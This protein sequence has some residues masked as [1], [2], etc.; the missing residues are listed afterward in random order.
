VAAGANHHLD[1][2]RL[3]AAQSVFE[4]AAMVVCQL[5]LPLPV[6]AHAVVLAQ[7]HAVPVLLNP[8]PALALPESLLRGLA[9]L[10][11]NEGE[12]ALLGGL[13]ISDVPSAQ[14]A[15]A[16]LRSAG[17]ACVIV[18]LGARG[19]VAASDMGGAAWPALPVAAID[20]TGA[21]DAFV[22]AFAVAQSRGQPLPES[23]AFAQRAAAWSVQRR[24]AQAA[25]PYADDLDRTDPQ[26]P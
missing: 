11:P 18:T 1:A 26:A 10:V 12:A 16:R 6:V 24:G 17:A 15:A 13:E 4:G 2:A 3:N 21:G 8:A 19:V 20:T 9:Y 23:I 25:M 22:G 5:E 7:R 14:A